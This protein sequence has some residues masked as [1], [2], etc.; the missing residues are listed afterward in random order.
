MSRLLNFQGLS[1]TWA[2]R[3]QGEVEE[4]E[5]SQ[6]RLGRA[7]FLRNTREVGDLVVGER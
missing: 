7:I 1:S 6:D 5:E 3:G 4:E 2:E